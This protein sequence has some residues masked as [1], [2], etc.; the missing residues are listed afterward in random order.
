LARRELEVFFQ[1]LILLAS[2]RV[3]TCEALVRWRHPEKGLIS[4]A[5]FIPVAEESGLIIPIGEWV[6]NEACLQAAQWPDEIAVAVNLSPLQFKSGRLAETIS[7]AIQHSGI[8][9]SRLQLEI[10]ESVM[11]DENETN[12]KTLQEIRRL[13]AKISMDDF[14]TGYSSLGYLRSFPFDK[15]KVDRGFI[16]DL[17]EGRESLAIIRAVAGIGRS[18]GIT[19]TVEGVETQAQLDAVN[20]E[21]FD[22]AQ[23]YL[24]SSPMPASD[25]LVFLAERR[26]AFANSGGSSEIGSS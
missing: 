16:N 11:L 14:G 22:E 3:S 7:Q 17:P 18:L 15:I 9:A 6:L 13:G 1:P 25:L 4:P 20:A 8:A 26:R 24:F 12:L 5:E 2:Q 10:T 19:T 21:G 23:G